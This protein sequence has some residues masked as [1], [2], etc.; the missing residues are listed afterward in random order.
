MRRREREEVTFHLA[1]NI[2]QTFPSIIGKMIVPF[3]FG[4]W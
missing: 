2:G 1:L 4:A 3:I